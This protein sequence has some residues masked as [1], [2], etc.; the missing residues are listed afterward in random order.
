MAVLQVDSSLSKPPAGKHMFRRCQQANWSQSAFHTVSFS[1]I[2]RSSNTPQGTSLIFPLYI[3]PSP[4][5][6]GPGPD[7]NNA[8]FNGWE[9]WQGSRVRRAVGVQTRVP[10]KTNLS[11]GRGFFCA[12]VAKYKIR[13]GHKGDISELP[14]KKTCWRWKWALKAEMASRR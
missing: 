6:R 5:P 4:S 7:S 11:C 9:F 1:H 8:V 13:W 14:L 3:F 2:I 12:C 10:F